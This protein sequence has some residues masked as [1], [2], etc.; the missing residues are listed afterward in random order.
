VGEFRTR[1][2]ATIASG[3]LAD[4]RHEAEVGEL[5]TRLEATIA[6]AN[7][8]EERHRVEVEESIAGVQAAMLTIEE[9][10]EKLIETE[11]KYQETEARAR[12]AES[13]SQRLHLISRLSFAL[14]EQVFGRTFKM[15]DE[16]GG[17]TISPDFATDAH[18]DKNSSKAT[19][20]DTNGSA[21]YGD[22]SSPEKLRALFDALNN[23]QV[24]DDESA[25]GG[26]RMTRALDK[27]ATNED[28]IPT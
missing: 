20:S 17:F 22:F 19:E 14:V 18:A 3:R 27:P 16:K 8:A 10:R 7:Q 9:T 24:F 4:E 5:R 2:E 13:R 21:A 28:G 12:R 25:G 26:P 23:A 1:L 6:A 15:S 11:A